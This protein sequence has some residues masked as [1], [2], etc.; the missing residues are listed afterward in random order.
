MQ[1]RFVAWNDLKL[2]K[3]TK[4][5]FSGEKIFSEFSPESPVK[6][7]DKDYWNSDNWDPMGYGQDYDFE[8]LFFEQIKELNLKVPRPSFAGFNLE[9]SPYCK[10][11][12]NIKDCYLVVSA[13]SLEKCCYGYRITESRD[14]FDC[15]FLS[16]SEL[17]YQ[18]FITKNCYKAFFSSYCDSCQEIYFCQNCVNC[19]NCFGCTNLKHQQYHIFNK[20]YSKEEYFEKTKELDVGSFE[21][22]KQVSIK[23]REE[24]IKYPKK[25]AFGKKQC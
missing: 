4:D 15:T 3:D 12:N 14:S 1:R 18:S 22:V 25:F 24:H 11:S 7:C 17:C 6:V 23:A 20:E 2:Y 8:K 9:N 16:N 21:V 19:S 5:C 13:S 10:N